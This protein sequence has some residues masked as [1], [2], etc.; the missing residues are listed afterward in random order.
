MKQVTR[1]LLIALFGVVG[2][3]SLYGSWIV[4]A[5]AHFY[6]V[7]AAY[8]AREMIG[9]QTPRPFWKDWLSYSPLYLPMLIA[10]VVGIYSLF[11]VYHLMFRFEKW[12]GESQVDV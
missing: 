5:I 2:V 10:G 9:S 8:D 11:C 12:R 1:I 6:V 4:G 3:F 7:D